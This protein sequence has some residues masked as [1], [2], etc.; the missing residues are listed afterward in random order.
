MLIE[1]DLL[2][3]ANLR[4]VPKISVERAALLAGFNGVGK[5]MSMRLL[6]LCSGGQPWQNQPAAWE[7]L[8]AALTGGR[9]RL[10][11][12]DGAD[13]IIWDLRP[14]VWPEISDDPGRGPLLPSDDWFE[15]TI[16]GKQANL[17]SVASIIEVR[18]VSGDATLSQTVA[19][20]I[21]HLA[22]RFQLA[23]DVARS[24]TVVAATDLME[25]AARDI[26]VATGTALE[27]AVR[28]R[29]EALQTLQDLQAKLSAATERRALSDKA[30]STAGRLAELAE[31]LPG[32]DAAISE[33]DGQVK[34]KASE[35]ETLRGRLRTAEA[36]AARFESAR[37]D[38]ENARRLAETHRT[39]L[40]QANRQLAEGLARLEIDSTQPDV[41]RRLNQR[42]RAQQQLLEELRA[43]RHA[44]DATPLLDQT[45]RELVEVLQRARARGIG[46]AQVLV[47]RVDEGRPEEALTFDRL[48]DGVLERRR[49]LAESPASGTT[50]LDGEIRRAEATS[51]QISATRA[52][53]DESQRLPPLVERAEERIR[54]ALSGAP[55]AG[56]LSVLRLETD[57]VE[58]DLTE[59]SQQ[60]AFL[61]GRRLALADGS[62]PEDLEAQLDV[63]LSRLGVESADQLDEGHH[64]L[65]VEVAQTQ[66]AYA[67]AVEVV[68]RCAEELRA[69]E[70][71]YQIARR[72]VA[73]DRVAASARGASETQ[74][75]D[76]AD[77]AEARAIELQELPNHLL[78]VQ[79]ALARVSDY[80]LG[81]SGR[82]AGGMQEAVEFW[83]NARVSRWFRG[84]TVRKALFPSAARVDV[85][86]SRRE[87]KWYDATSGVVH[88]LPFEAF[89][90]GQQAFAYTKARLEELGSS[91]SLNR[92]I[93]LDEFGAFIARDLM[94]DLRSMLAERRYSHP[95]DRVLLIL[96]VTE[97]PREQAK[98]S[99][100]LARER[101]LSRA[102]QLE[103]AQYFVEE[104]H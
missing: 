69:A 11:G 16:D 58:Q 61:A 66:S 25:S 21:R 98:V 12:I 86:L 34:T 71:A 29:D 79:A 1:I 62:T 49:A 94:D 37:R 77:R 28:R 85:D 80:V 95:S 59:L 93:A 97:N 51:K 30:T 103:S 99:S 3:P 26:R 44:I 78:A 73:A 72:K 57:K 101:Y 7:S 87:V 10:S 32:L 15:I 96:P 17:A 55:D 52:W 22:D 27:V 13:E 4:A 54:N 40:Q 33:L 92:L 8:R 47:V 83:L 24:A 45:L 38:I 90:S 20:E 67:S 100:Q 102:A 9:V 14:K 31:A 104:L 63:I 2:G 74:M 75:M 81:R 41:Q 88:E 53:F 60:R 84:D 89:S 39:S 42:A 5:S 6:E 18:R 56:S 64:Q 50:E 68:E 65:D 91:Q 46:S 36:A 76:V 19:M 43:R 48:R 23:Q 82:D 70:L 35:Y